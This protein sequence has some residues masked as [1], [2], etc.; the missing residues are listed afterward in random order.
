MRLWMRLNPPLRTQLSVT[1][2][3]WLALSSRIRTGK[4]LPCVSAILVR[5]VT[6][7]TTDLEHDMLTMATDETSS[8][9]TTLEGADDTFLILNDMSDAFVVPLAELGAK[10]SRV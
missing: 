2:F 3:D 5:T 1:K 10:C 7:N 8:L 6:N 4:K 9:D